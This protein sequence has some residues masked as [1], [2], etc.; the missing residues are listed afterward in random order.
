L[1]SSAWSQRS[2]LTTFTLVPG[3]GGT[4]GGSAIVGVDPV[5]N[6]G[7]LELSYLVLAQTLGMSVGFMLGAIIRHFAGAIVAYFVYSF[8]LTNLTEALAQTQEWFADLRP[9]VDFNYAQ[10]ALFEGSVSAMQWA[11]LG[12]T[13]VAWVV[14]PMAVGLWTLM[15]SEVK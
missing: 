10:G 4:I 6:V 13:S 8:V 3:G 12:V 1:V 14:V 5:W 7:A 2:G 11:N 15:R 9:W